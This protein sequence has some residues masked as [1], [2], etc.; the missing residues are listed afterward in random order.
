MKVAVFAV[1]LVIGFVAAAEEMT[2]EQ[3]AK[4]KEMVMKALDTKGETLHACK[5]DA[6]CAEKTHPE[7]GDMS[8][9]CM[10]THVCGPPNMPHVPLVGKF[11]TMP[12]LLQ[13][14][15]IQYTRVMYL[16]RKFTKNF[17]DFCFTLTN[18]F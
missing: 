16:K 15:A 17:V 3:Q 14:L 7:H 6:D 1:L 18:F 12:I 9:C 4:A 11:Y 2:E 10:N 5:A 8:K 13:R